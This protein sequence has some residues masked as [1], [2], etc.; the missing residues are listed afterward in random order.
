MYGTMYVTFIVDRDKI[1][2]R[3]ATAKIEDVRYLCSC[4]FALIRVPR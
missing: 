4:A 3:L 2:R 1:F